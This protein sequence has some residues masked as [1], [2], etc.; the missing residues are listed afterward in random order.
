[1]QVFFCIVSAFHIGKL[2]LYVIYNFASFDYNAIRTR[3]KVVFLD[4]TSSDFYLHVL[5]EFLFVH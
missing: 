3:E 4:F 5:L 1:M 2:M